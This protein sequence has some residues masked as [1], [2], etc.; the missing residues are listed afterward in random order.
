MIPELG[1]EKY[2]IELGQEKY[3]MSLELINVPESKERLKG[4]D[5]SER[6]GPSSRGSHYSNT[7]QFK[8]QNKI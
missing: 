5:V 2:K 8:C 4:W 6:W 3:K 1:Q 7:R